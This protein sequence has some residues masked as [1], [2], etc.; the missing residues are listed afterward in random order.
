MAK[1]E[2]RIVKLETNSNI[3]RQKFK[4]I[5]GDQISLE[6]QIFFCLELW[7]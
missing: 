3:K 2:S 6:Q 7:N 4:T 5:E 1:F